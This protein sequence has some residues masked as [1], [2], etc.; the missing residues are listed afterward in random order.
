MT[1]FRM[2]PTKSNFPGRW[3][4]TSC[5]ICSFEDTNAHLFCC[6]GYQDIVTPDIWYD[7]F[8]DENILNDTATLRNAASILL[9]VIERLELVQMIAKSN[10]EVTSEGV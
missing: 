1:R 4:G 2:L 3:N 6:P 7:M 10:K 8:W 5:N 9:S